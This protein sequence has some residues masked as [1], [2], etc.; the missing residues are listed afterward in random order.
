MNGQLYVVTT[1]VSVREFGSF[2]EAMEYFNTLTWSQDKA[3]FDSNSEP[4]LHESNSN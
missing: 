3:I 2:N 4:M 1:D